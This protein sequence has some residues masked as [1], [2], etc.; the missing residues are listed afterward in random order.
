LSPVGREL[1]ADLRSEAEQH[2]E[3]FFAPLTA[4][5]RR[6]LDELLAKLAASLDD[7]DQ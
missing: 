4:S 2:G 3:R 6:Q 1:L 7:A 5:E